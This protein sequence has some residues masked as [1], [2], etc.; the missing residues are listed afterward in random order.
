MTRVPLLALSREF[1]DLH[2]WKS[3]SHTVSLDL[4]FL[5][6]PLFNFEVIFGKFVDSHL[7][8]FIYIN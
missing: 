5:I 6:K 4:E 2:A 7:F 1:L 8:E 3:Q